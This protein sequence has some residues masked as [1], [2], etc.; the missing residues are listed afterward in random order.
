MLYR[1]KS[2]TGGVALGRDTV[3]SLDFTGANWR[4]GATG[5]FAFTGTLT[6]NGTTYRLGG[7][8]GT[9]SL[10][11]GNTLTGARNLDVD[12]S[13]PLGGSV[14]LGPANN[15]T[16]ATTIGGGTLRLGSSGALGSTSSISIASGATLDVA[17]LAAGFTLGSGKTLLGAGRVLGRFTIGTG[18]TVSPGTPAAPFGQLALGNFSLNG[19]YVADIAASGLHDLLAIDGDLDLSSVT[20]SLTVNASGAP[21]GDYVLATYSGILTGTFNSVI[22]P[23]NT[24]I[25]YGTG[26]N[27]Q[28]RIVPE[29]SVSL[30]A[31]AGVLTLARRRKVA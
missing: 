3:G 2:S 13:G 16:G 31:F 20:D 30:L 17:S 6:P 4:L 8:G 7:G 22:L 10:A 28:I 25:D 29:P 9:L 1:A 12:S 15:F 5:A 21:A 23:P 27:S 11:N 26:T 19:N 18:A 14:F 24:A